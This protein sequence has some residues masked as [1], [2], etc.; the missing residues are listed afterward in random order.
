MVRFVLYTP[1]RLSLFPSLYDAVTIV[2]IISTT[3]V[4]KENKSRGDLSVR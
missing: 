2:V 3:I 4:N 1:T